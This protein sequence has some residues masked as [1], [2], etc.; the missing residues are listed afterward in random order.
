MDLT[1]DELNSDRSPTPYS[2]GVTPVPA[3]DTFIENWFPAL[4]PSATGVPAYLAGGWGARF[5][6]RQP[7]SPA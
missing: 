7:H 2:D 6:Y 5:E 3:T 1:I 4:P